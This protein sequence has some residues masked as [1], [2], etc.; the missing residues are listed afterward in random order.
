MAKVNTQLPE[1]P[2][3]KI[4]AAVRR[5]AAA[6]DQI[7]KE[8]YNPEPQ[9][10]PQDP[11]QNDPPQDPPKPGVSADGQPPLTAKP[12]EP[13]S[14]QQSE[15]VA[16]LAVPETAP[17]G[18]DSWE[19]R[20]KT[21]KGRWDR[22]QTTVN[23]LSARI[24][25]LERLLASAQAT[26][27]TAPKDP[28]KPDASQTVVLSEEDKQTWGEDMLSVV[29]RQARLAVK[30]DLDAR[31]RKI[32]ELEAQLG[33]VSSFVSQDAHKNMLNR[34]DADLPSWREQNENPEFLNWLRLPDAYSGA[35]R[36]DLLRQAWGQNDA[37]RVL[38][39]FRG[40]LSEEAAVA[41][42]EPETPPPAQQGKVSLDSLA[43]P[44]RARSATAAQPAGTPEKPIIT[45]AQVTQFYAD[46]AAGRYHG[47]DAK[48][49]SD[50]AMIFA[51][52][53]EGRIR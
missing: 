7:H 9:D 51:A 36:G 22:Q 1:D 42:A 14:R 27:A 6:A 44:G 37:H 26:A 16:P 3:V 47:Q 49:A 45:R 38:A 19:Q 13:A 5:A 28:P 21:I 50:E 30:A 35:I 4:P 2:S 33:G 46:V 8:A 18:N 11:P 40:F 17:N 31:D 12:A 41:P 43:A 20:Y 34:L 10:P 48:K 52:Q 24:G 53:R 15:P 32:A 25:E 29:A 39:F 23:Q